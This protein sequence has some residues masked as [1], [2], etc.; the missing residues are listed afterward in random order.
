MVRQRRPRPQKPSGGASD[1]TDDGLLPN[2]RKKP[3]HPARSVYR[4]R[5][6]E[7]G[8]FFNRVTVAKPPPQPP[9]PLSSYASATDSDTETETMGTSASAGTAS[10]SA[11]P[12]EDSPMKKTFDVD[13]LKIAQA[14]IEDG[15]ASHYPRM[16]LSDVDDDLAL[17][18]VL[19]QVSSWEYCNTI[20]DSYLLLCLLGFLAAS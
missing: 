16:V 3:W 5:L 4:E 12:L 8:S 1:R 7:V 2:G 19:W 20:Q 10:V 6:D 18:V 11:A 15:V 13:C 14:V 9:T 17:Y